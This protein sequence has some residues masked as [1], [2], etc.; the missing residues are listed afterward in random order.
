MTGR[1][2]RNV[3]GEH[4]GKTIGFFAVLMTASGIMSEPVVVLQATTVHR[5]LTFMAFETRAV[6]LLIPAV[7]SCLVMYVPLGKER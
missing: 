4:G 5:S 1:S 7:R 2:K 3:V 6:F